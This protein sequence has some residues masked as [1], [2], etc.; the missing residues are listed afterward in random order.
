MRVVVDT[1]VAV[2]GLLWDGPPNDILKRAR[3]G[4]VV[5]VACQESVKELQRILQYKRFQARLSMLGISAD[6]VSA[7]YMNLVRFVPNP[8]EVPKVIREDP[9]DNLF[10]ALASEGKAQLV[11]TGDHHLLRLGRHMEIEIVTPHEACKVIETLITEK[12]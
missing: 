8:K 10:L 6:E 1:N 4:F 12:R 3:D 5:L 7:Y 11:V 2:S 9:F